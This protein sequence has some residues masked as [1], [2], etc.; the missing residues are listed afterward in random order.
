MLLLGTTENTEQLQDIILWHFIQ[1]HCIY[2][3][4]PA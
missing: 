4:F 1:C 2:T 3:I